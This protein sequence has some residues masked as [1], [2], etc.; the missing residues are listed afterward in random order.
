MVFTTTLPTQLN[1]ITSVDHTWPC[2]GN[3]RTPDWHCRPKKGKIR[4][5]ISKRCDRHTP[6]LIS[7]HHHC[8][9]WFQNHNITIRSIHS[10][11]DLHSFH[12]MT[13][14][15][16]QCLR[17]WWSFFPDSFCDSGSGS[18]PL[19]GRLCLMK[20]LILINMCLGAA[21]PLILWFIWFN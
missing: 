4:S 14:G 18:M 21:L 9:D 17:S 10:W 12:G 5:K 15:Q 7:N 19:F 8:H 13:K 16:P 2:W 6:R 3:P 1:S 11:W 20:T